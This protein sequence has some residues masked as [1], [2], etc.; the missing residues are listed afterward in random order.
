MSGHTVEPLGPE[1]WKA[2]AALAERHNG[3]Q[4]GCW[5]TWF[6]RGVGKDFANDP[7]GAEGNRAW[8]ERLVREGRAHAALVLDG[9]DAVAWCQFGPPEQLTH[10]NFRKEYDAGLKA[11]PK[12]RLTCLFVDKHYRR[13]GVAGEAVRGAL[14]L[15][16]KAGGGVVEAYPQDTQGS[17]AS[18]THLYN[19]T[20]LM[21]ESAGFRYERPLGKKH[22]V[23]RKTVRPKRTR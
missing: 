23:M 22:C 2:F 8:K 4:G 14:D 1:T 11:L 18:S 3:I 12:Y 9:D 16:A 5:C 21:F 7:R 6:H 20:R 15:I 10:I 19:G 17:K 13:Q